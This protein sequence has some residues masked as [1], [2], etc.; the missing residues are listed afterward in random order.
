H[1]LFNFV[2]FIWLNIAPNASTQF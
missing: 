1:M 2:T